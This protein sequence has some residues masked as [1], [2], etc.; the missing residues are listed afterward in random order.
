[1]GPQVGRQREGPGWGSR[2]RPR[3]KG[4]DGGEAGARAGDARREGRE[5]L[6]DRGGHEAA[7]KPHETG[8]WWVSLPS[9]SRYMSTLIINRVWR[10][11]VWGLPVLF[12]FPCE[13]TQSREVA[14][15]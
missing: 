4:L 6:R 9:P 14:A 11:E 7:T 15:T 12:L 1:M 8:N 10:W 2:T 5:G 3:E 13:E